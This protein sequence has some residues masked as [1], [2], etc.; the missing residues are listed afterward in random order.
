MI[1]TQC[2]ITSHL[3]RKEGEGVFHHQAGQSVGVENK[4]ISL[5]FPVSKRRD[6]TSSL[7]CTR[8]RGDPLPNDCVHP[9]DLRL[10]RHDVDRT[11][12]LLVIIVLII[13]ELGADIK[14][15]L[16]KSTRLTSFSSAH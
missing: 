16:Y 3:K 5:G 11:R 14:P 6:I 10:A 8:D 15:V 2:H 13:D 12:K 7:H 9:S 4:V 1:V